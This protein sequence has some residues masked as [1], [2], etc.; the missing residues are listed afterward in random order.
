MLS[1]CQCVDEL[2]RKHGQEVFHRT[3][4]N[5]TTLIL[6]LIFDILYLSEKSLFSAYTNTHQHNVYL[7]RPIYLLSVNKPKSVLAEMA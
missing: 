4:L 3:G 6:I 2:I 5:L 7:F 1:D